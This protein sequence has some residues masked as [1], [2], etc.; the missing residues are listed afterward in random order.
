MPGPHLP[1]IADSYLTTPLYYVNGSPHLGHAYTTFLGDLLKRYREQR[2]EKVFLLTGTDEHGEKIQ[3]MAEQQGTTPQAL[4][5][6]YAQEFRAT[7]QAFHLKIDCFYRTSASAH[8][9]AVQ[10]TLQRLKDEGKIVFRHFEGQYCVGCERFMTDSELTPEGLCPDHLKKPELKSE[11]NY[12]F[13]M[14]RYQAPLIQFL[15][16][17]ESSIQPNAY[18]Q[19]MLSFLKMPLGDLCISRPKSRVYWG[20]ELPFD[21]QFVT[22]VWFDA[23]LNYIIALG[24][25]A[26]SWQQPLWQQVTHLIA[27]D[28]VKAH[29]IYWNT[30]LM[31]LE[32]PPVPRIQVSGY[33]LMG[34]QKMSKS[35]NNVLRP[36]ELE[37]TYGAETLR[38]FLFKEMNYGLDGHFTLEH[39]L[40]CVNAHLANGIGNLVSRVHTLAVK[41]LGRVEVPQSL[42]TT[43]DQKLLAQREQTLVLW[44]QAFAAL[45]YHQALKV[46]CELVTQCDLY[47][48]E[49]KPWALAKLPDGRQQLERVLGVSLR[50]IQALGALIAPV[51]PQAAQKIARAL[52]LPDTAF[53]TRA[54]VLQETAA[55]DL[56]AET[57]KL[58]LRI[59]TPTQA[60]TQKTSNPL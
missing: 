50:M 17:N 44:E 6:H 54:W 52:G 48:N 31:A 27:K 21:D 46:W 51:L 18:R 11:A 13:L 38:F 12:F 35:L 15:Q 2:G 30:M 4:V 24:W 45:K 55:Y 41:H 43:A 57:P 19:E 16:D 59:Q 53:D 58:F 26:P 1:L 40:L 7:W 5:D 9:D 49:E 33:W 34:D 10:K 25:P 47:L 56:S 29:A 23:L 14:S 22:Y 8:R 37:Q 39:F 20:I 32:L 28:I 3:Q 42:L 36:L 60:A